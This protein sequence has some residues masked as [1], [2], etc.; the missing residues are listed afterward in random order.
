MY[1]SLSK[2]LYICRLIEVKVKFI[3]YNNLK[4]PESDE[5][6]HDCYP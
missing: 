5:T 6:G 1:Y 3:Q 4:E 2:N